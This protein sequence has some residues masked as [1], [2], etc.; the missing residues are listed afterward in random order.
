MIFDTLKNQKTIL[1]LS[2]YKI[3]FKTFDYFFLDESSLFFRP[4]AVKIL[5]FCLSFVLIFLKSILFPL[6]GGMLVGLFLF[7]NGEIACFLVYYFRTVKM[8]CV[9][10]M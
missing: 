5:G 7:V 3:F 8:L 4:F 1:I 10:W 9:T 6:Y 2:Y